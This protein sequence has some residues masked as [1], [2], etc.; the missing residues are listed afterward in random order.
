LAY[1]VSLSPQF[2]NRTTWARTGP[3]SWVSESSWQAQ[4]VLAPSSARCL[5]FGVPRCA[6]DS[7]WGVLAIAAGRGSLKAGTKLS[8][9]PLAHDCA[10]RLHYSQIA[11][12]LS[13]WRWARQGLALSKMTLQSCVGGRLLSRACVTRE[14]AYGTIGAEG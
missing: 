3:R 8:P 1:K 10:R 5:M 13:R 4:Y 12:W 6:G 7:T 2:G 14:G 11:V 9:L